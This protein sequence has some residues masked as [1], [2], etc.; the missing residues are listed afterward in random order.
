RWAGPAGSAYATVSLFGE[1]DRPGPLEIDRDG[2]TTIDLGGGWRFSRALELRIAIRNALDEERFASPD[3][4][5][6]LAAGRT[7]TLGLNGRFRLPSRG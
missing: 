3:P 7:V 4:T 6:P 5:A 1:D 2:Y